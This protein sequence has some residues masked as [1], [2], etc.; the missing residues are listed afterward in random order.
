MA[1][2]TQWYAKCQAHA[3][4]SAYAAHR[5]FLTGDAVNVFQPASTPWMQTVA[6][7]LQINTAGIP[8]ELEEGVRRFGGLL[9]GFLL[10]RPQFIVN[11]AV[12]TVTYDNQSDRLYYGISGYNPQLLNMQIAPVLAARI[13]QLPVQQLANNRQVHSAVLGGRSPQVCSEF[14]ALN[15]ALRAG[16]NEQ[17]LSCWT[18]RIREMT[19][20]PQCANCRITVNRNHLGRVWTG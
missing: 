17:D 15:R 13:G 2:W 3:H 5:R 10:Y 20:M 11:S 1:L 9:E 12:T 16:A 7:I 19:P 18:F 14:K 8:P 6:G 4:H